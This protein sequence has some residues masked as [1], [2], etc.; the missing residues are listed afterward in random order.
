MVLLEQA[1]KL[2]IGGVTGLDVA[3]QG[4]TSIMG[5]YSIEA[6]NAKN[7]SDILFIAAAGGATDVKGL[8]TELGR[9]S[10]LA[11]Q[12]GISFNELAAAT[13]AATISGLNTAEATTSVLGALNAI[14]TPGDELRAVFHAIGYESG[15]AAIAQLGFADT[16]KKVI[17]QTDGPPTPLLPYLA[18]CD[19]CQPC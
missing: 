15:T 13:S 1:Q 2:A 18:T 19:R 9:V 10:G 6:K 8:A 5:A 3:T 14:L 16:L 17:A 11:A 7:I 4:L 12:A